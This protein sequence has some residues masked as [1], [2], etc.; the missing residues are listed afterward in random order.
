M[1]ILE[2]YDI[3][4]NDEKLYE[5]AFTHSSYSAKHDLDYDYERLEFLGDSVLN[6]L[7]SEYLQNMHP[8]YSEGKLVNNCRCVR[9]IPGSPLSGLRH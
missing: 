8:S 1:N 7:V 9:I 5:I 4:P 3:V 6:M 2:K